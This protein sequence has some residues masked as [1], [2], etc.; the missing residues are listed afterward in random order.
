MKDRG[1]VCALT[2]LRA[3]SRS[4]RS[5]LHS[6]S[7]FNLQSVYRFPH[8]MTEFLGTIIARDPLIAYNIPFVFKKVHL[9]SQASSVR[10]GR[11]Q[12]N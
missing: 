3:V 10:P 6:F 1:R 8:I 5:G 11:V 2:D 9:F 7:R 4:R 12:P